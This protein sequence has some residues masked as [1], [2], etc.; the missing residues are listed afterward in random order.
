MRC[1]HQAE[2]W[3]GKADGREGAPWRPDTDHV[4]APMLD[5]LR[6]RGG[7]DQALYYALARASGGHNYQPGLQRD[8]FSGRQADRDPRYPLS[9]QGEYGPAMQDVIAVSPADRFDQRPLREVAVGGVH[10]LARQSSG[11]PGRQAG[12][13]EHVQ[14]GGARRW[15]ENPFA[16][17]LNAVPA[18]EGLHDASRRTG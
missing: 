2:G 13:W 7:S 15:H 16:G 10:D 5:L 18:Q 3:S 8:L 11:E 14:C 4:H 12:G 17:R 9:M 6:L 1:E